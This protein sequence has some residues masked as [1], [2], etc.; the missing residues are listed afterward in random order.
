[1]FGYCRAVPC[2]GTVGQRLV[3]ALL[4]SALFGHCRTA[5]CL[6]TVGQRLVW[7]LLDSACVR[8]CRTAY[9]R[10]SMLERQRERD[11]LLKNAEAESYATLAWSK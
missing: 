10:K 1:M 6:G 5:P 8:H 4:D 7:A 9:C 2:L 3:W 11:T